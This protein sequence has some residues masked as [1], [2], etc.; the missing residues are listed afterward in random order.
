MYTDN[1]DFE[2]AVAKLY[3]DQMRRDAA[4]GY[5]PESRVR[6]AE[7]DLAYVTAIYT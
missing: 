2:I 7:E 1:P 3:L 5:V 6:D 4:L